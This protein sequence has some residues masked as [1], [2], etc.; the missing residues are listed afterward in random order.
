M[1][2]L[3]RAQAVI[4][5]NYGDEGKGLMTDYFASLDPENSLIVRFNGGA[6]AGHTVVCP[7]GR[8]HVFSHFGSASFLNCPTYLSKFFIVN[9]LL[10]VKEL[11]E[12]LAK[13]V[14]PKVFVDPQAIVSTPFDVFI[15]QEV[16]MQRAGKRHGSC[17]V[18]INETVTR[19]LSAP[20]FCTR[21][22]NL[23]DEA[24]LRHHLQLLAMNWLPSRLSAHGID[25]NSDSVKAFFNIIDI[26]I[27]RY[28]HDVSAFLNEVSISS[29]VFAGQQIIFEGA[30]GLMLDEMRRDQFPHLT[31]S[32]TGLTNVIKL[33]PQFG[34]DDL[35]VTYMTRTYLTRH[36]AGPLIG[37]NSFSFP[38]ATN[39]PN[40]F[41]GALRFA[42]LDFDALCYSIELDLSTALSE[43]SAITANIAMTCADQLPV[44]ISDESA[45]PVPIRFVSYGPTRNDVLH[46]SCLAAHMEK[47]ALVS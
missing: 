25:L 46:G 7:D 35:S 8:R 11:N 21:V 2:T 26:V 37:E 45:Y 5:A 9:P 13:G 24:D 14:R 39:I 3:R 17:G 38:D 42:S 4:G 6:Q 27:E 12:L 30:Q 36:G 31:R 41:Q 44:P 43:F 34:I 29:G 10:F 19:C 20:E 18:G 1:R 40:Q 28:L 15:N 16:E 23:F 22:A 32:R 33:L 47:H